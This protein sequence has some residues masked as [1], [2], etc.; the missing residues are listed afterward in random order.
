MKRKL[1]L[2]EL[3]IIEGEF[4]RELKEIFPN[5]NFREVKKSNF[6]S[7]YTSYDIEV[8]ITLESLEKLTENYYFTMC[9][10]YINFK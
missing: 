5:I 4:L 9:S 3:G 1:Q 7:Y 8:N 10:E 2:S 6:D